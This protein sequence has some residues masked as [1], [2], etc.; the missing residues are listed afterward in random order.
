MLSALCHLPAA[1]AGRPASSADATADGASHPFDF[2]GLRVGTRVALKAQRNTKSQTP[3]E[4]E[5]MRFTM[6]MTALAALVAS[7]GV[8]GVALANEGEGPQ[9]AGRKAAILAKF[10]TNHD[11]QL[12]DSEKAAMRA[13]FKEKR[14]ERRAE[15]VARFDTNKDG[16]LEP[17]ERKAMRDTLTSERFSKLDTN[18]DGVISLAEFQAGAGAGHRHNKMR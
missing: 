3:K 1:L 18:H 9:S 4:I 2:N 8:T 7:L 11:G 10:D 5:K 13:A 12:D 6:K 14:Q 15:L 16:K 17:A